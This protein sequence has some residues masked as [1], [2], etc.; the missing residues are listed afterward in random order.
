MKKILKQIILFLIGG[1]MYYLLEMIFRGHSHWTMFLLGGGCFAYL[2]LINEEITWEMPLWAQGLLGSLVITILEFAV[3]ILVN[4]DMGWNVWDYSNM[5]FNLLGQICLP[6]SLL[7]ILVS[8]VAIVLDDYLR[9]W[10]FNEE[11][12]HYC[13]RKGEKDGKNV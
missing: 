1:A 9:Y 7:W 12:P 13:L 3:G 8:L 2:G 4:L 11:K 5:P 10:L 6:F